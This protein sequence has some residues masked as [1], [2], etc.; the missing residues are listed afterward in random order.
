L[1]ATVL[2]PGESVKHELKPERHAYVQVAR[3]SVTLNGK[4]LEAGDGAA[5]SRE[6]ALELVGVNDSEVLLFDL[7]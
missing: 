1:Y 4:A 2:G 5:I 6:P 3:G 7:A